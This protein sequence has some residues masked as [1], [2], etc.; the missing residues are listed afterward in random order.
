MQSGIPAFAGMT[1]GWGRWRS[2]PTFTLPGLDPGILF[3]GP[4]KDRRIKPGEGEAV[5]LHQK[6]LKD[7][8][9]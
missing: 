3:R 8:I 6:L 1:G 4:E 7:Q 5:E 9:P 2:T